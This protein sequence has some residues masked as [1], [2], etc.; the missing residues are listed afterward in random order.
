MTSL[1]RSLQFNKRTPKKH[2][3]KSICCTVYVASTVTGIKEHL[4]LICNG[5]NSLL[6]GHIPEYYRRIVQQHVWNSECS[7][8]APVISEGKRNKQ[9]SGKSFCAERFSSLFR[10][11]ECLWDMG[12][13]TGLFFF[14][15]IKKYNNIHRAREQMMMPHKNHTNATHIKPEHFR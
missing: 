1:L 2:L 15:K 9:P 11:W 7:G 14:K 13:F 10:D 5:N 8:S 6:C 3:V 12:T 4:I